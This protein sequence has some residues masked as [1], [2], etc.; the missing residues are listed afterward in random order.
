MR[1]SNEHKPEKTGNRWLQRAR[2]AFS[3]LRE[4]ERLRHE[5]AVLEADGMLDTVLDDVMITGAEIGPLLRNHPASG[6]L[7]TEMV[8]RLDIGDAFEKNPA[9]ARDMWRVCTMC[10]ALPECKRWMRSDATEGYE[11]F[12]PNADRLDEMRNGEH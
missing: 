7:L 8:E 6:R 12:C 11:Q 2:D 1:G 5:F 9:V 3:D 4:R 10:S